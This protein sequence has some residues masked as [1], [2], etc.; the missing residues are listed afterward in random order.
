MS[1]SHPFHFGCLILLWLLRLRTPNCKFS[2]PWFFSTYVINYKTAV[3]TL[4]LFCFLYTS[5]NYSFLDI[6]VQRSA[7]YI[8]SFFRFS[9]ISFISLCLMYM[10]VFL[11]QY[12]YSHLLFGSC[13]TWMLC[14]HFIVWLWRES[15]SE[16]LSS[17]L[18][19]WYVQGVNYYI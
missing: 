7:Y 9:F 5:T 18:M 10:H 12:W 4:H 8:D 15:M 17:L 2:F 1:P 16:R 3:S 14:D 19:L 13:N 6:V 11:T